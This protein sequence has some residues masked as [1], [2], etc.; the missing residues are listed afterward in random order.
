MRVITGTAKGVSLLAPDGLLTRPTGDRAKVGMFN[1][2][3]FEIYGAVLDLFGGSGQLGIECLSRGAE[4]AVFVDG[5]REAV[6]VIRENLRRTRLEAGASVVCAD[7]MDYLNRCRDRFHI[8]LL[9]PPMRKNIW[10]M[11]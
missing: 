7:Y 9:D 4:R 6:A 2:I 1:I 11:P 8:I 5:R 10:K 3:Q